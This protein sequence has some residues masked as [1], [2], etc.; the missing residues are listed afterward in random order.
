MY[1]VHS[2]QE[3][4]LIKLMLVHS[5]A[6]DLGKWVACKDRKKEPLYITSKTFYRPLQPKQTLL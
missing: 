2:E 4:S 3:I 6:I 5:K 1:Y